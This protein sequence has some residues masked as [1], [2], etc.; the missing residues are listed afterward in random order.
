MCLILDIVVDIQFAE[1]VVN[2]AQP[3]SIRTWCECCGQYISSAQAQGSQ[4]PVQINALVIQNR[5]LRE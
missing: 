5:S 2:A 4:Y 1:M 3:N